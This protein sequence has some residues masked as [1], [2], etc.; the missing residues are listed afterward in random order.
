[1]PISIWMSSVSNKQNPQDSWAQWIDG[2]H[3]ALA[4]AKR[5]I[6]SGVTVSQ[7]WLESLMRSFHLIKGYAQAL[8]LSGVQSVAHELES[9]MV[10]LM[11]APS[12][13]ARAR[14]S[15]GEL[16]A[17]LSDGVRKLDGVLA[18]MHEIQLHAAA[19]REIQG[20]KPKVVAL[21]ARIEVAARGIAVD[22]RLAIR[23]ETRV[24]VISCSKRIGRRQLRPRFC[25]RFAIVLITAARARTVQ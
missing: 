3:E 15:D 12:K 21:F 20:G 25:T 10:A 8:G 17:L 4:E 14:L 16:V 1:M 9:R 13:G 22:V 6:A 2:L 24:R 7:P 23:F 19:R 18:R 11:S 5:L